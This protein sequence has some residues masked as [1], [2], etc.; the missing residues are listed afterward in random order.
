LLDAYSSLENPTE[1]QKVRYR[2]LL[3]SC[4]LHGYHLQT[5]ILP[6]QLADRQDDVTEVLEK[7]EEQLVPGKRYALVARMGSDGGVTPDW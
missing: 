7:L 5:A 6:G 3:R 4:I 1:Q 2:E